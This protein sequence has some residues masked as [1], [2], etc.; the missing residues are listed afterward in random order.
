MNGL[1]RRIS[2]SYDS[3]V[4]FHEFARIIQPIEL[5]PYLERIK[6]VTKGGRVSALN[7]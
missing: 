6:N 7:T 1:L 3:K 2:L 5:K 4:T